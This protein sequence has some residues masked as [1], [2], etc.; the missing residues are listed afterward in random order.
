MPPC[1]QDIDRVVNTMDETYDANFGDWIRN[2]DNCKIVGINMRK[3]VDEYNPSDFIVVVKWIVKDWTLKSII[4]FS[5]KLII[6]GLLSKTRKQYIQSIK[7]VTGFIYTWNPIFISEFLLASTREF[8]SKPRAAF[9]ADVIQTFE[10]KKF[11]E[12]LAQMECKLDE[13]TRDELNGLFSDGIYGPGKCDWDRT[14][15][16]INAFTVL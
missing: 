15:S 5:K 7:I 4:I 2:E 6:D 13:A 3:Y 10:K 16:L 8:P 9:F 11:N 14:E 1:L 12:I